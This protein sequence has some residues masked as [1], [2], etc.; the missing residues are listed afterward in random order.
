[1]TIQILGLAEGVRAQQFEQL[2]EALEAAAG[3]PYSDEAVQMHIDA[4]GGVE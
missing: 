1:M 4:A 3:E 2:R